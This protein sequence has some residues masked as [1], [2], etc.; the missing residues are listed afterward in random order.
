M[1]NG[2]A[3]FRPKARVQAREASTLARRA[4]VF[5]G[6]AATECSDPLES[7]K[8]GSPNV[9]VDGQLGPPLLQYTSTVEV[10]LKK[11]PHLPAGAFKTKRPAPDAREQCTY[12]GVEHALVGWSDLQ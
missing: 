7:V 11:P 3:V 4:D 12:C 9:A 10:E 6:E 2:T 5:T 8:V 1:A